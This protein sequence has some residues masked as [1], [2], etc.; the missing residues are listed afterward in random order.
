MKKRI[1]KFVII[2]IFLILILFV[3][4]ESCCEKTINNQYCVEAS[5]EECS[6]NVAYE[7]RACRYTTFCR[8][9]TCINLDEG[10]CSRDT[11]KALCL[12][13]SGASWDER[14]RDEIAV[15]QKGCAIFGTKTAFVT[16]IQA[17]ELAMDYGISYDFRE[18][19][20][21]ER[22][23]TSLVIS[24]DVGACVERKDYETDC[25][26]YVLREE[27]SGENF[28]FYSGLLCTADELEGVDCAPNSKETMCYEEGTS[29][30]VYFKDT[31]GNRANVYD[32]SMFLGNKNGNPKEQKEYWTY[33]KEPS[34]IVD[35][36]GNCGD[37]DYI[38]GSVCGEATT[39][40]PKYGNS[41][42]QSMSCEYHGKTYEHGES[43]CADSPG[44]YPHLPMK[45]VYNPANLDLTQKEID[46]IA[47]VREELEN[48]DKYNI[49]GSRYYKLVCWDGEV[50][51]YECMDYRQE[52][53][54]EEEIV[55]GFTHAE[56]VAND[57]L[58][59]SD[60]TNNE[61]C[62]STTNMCRWVQGYRVD[63]KNVNE[64]AYKNEPYNEEEQGTCVPLIPPGIDFWNPESNGQNYCT[65]AGSIVEIA[66]YE[67]HWMGDSIDVSPSRADVRDK[68]LE[69]TNRC[70][71]SCYAIPG[72]GVN[73]VGDE[74]YKN[75][76]E[77]LIR[78]VGSKNR[79]LEDLKKFT[80]AKNSELG[81]SQIEGNLFISDRRGYYCEGATGE[82]W[83]DEIKCSIIAGKNTNQNEK[84]IR[85]APIF[86]T[87]EEWFNSIT[88]KTGALG[89][90]GYKENIV[91]DSEGSILSEYITSEWS[92]V[93]KKG[94]PTGSSTEYKIWD[95]SGWIKENFENYL[96]ENT[97]I[98]RVGGE[99]NMTTC[100]DEDGY[101]YYPDSNGE[102]NDD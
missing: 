100:V 88:T 91:G 31:C 18:D 102:C 60:I 17:K 93:N 77:P 1:L 72:Y 86:W 80:K 11:E 41:V 85:K 59:C 67:T 83:G 28:E 12:S 92:K 94:A 76:I 16:E 9:G 44:T 71:S 64:K 95:G 74:N 2:F 8:R 101:T 26:N 49:P 7:E 19:L 25:K 30:K 6:G 81:I 97:G 89:D 15:C 33:I 29:T 48:T 53:C 40:N 32:A 69:K 87:N 47:K 24:K 66:Q 10:S 42:C 39:P 82:I 54:V 70:Y 75:E 22:E 79:D 20:N 63:R 73:F 36:S 57:Y 27:C 45:L 52:I 62:E 58:S 37:C 90:C 4:A 21:N 13:K 84:K 68:Y 65:L 50:K 3:N 43:W 78:D 61:Q 51:P 34:C 99:P 56:C 55:S 96:S 35:S 46:N 5:Q 14:D 98:F 38:G 23:C